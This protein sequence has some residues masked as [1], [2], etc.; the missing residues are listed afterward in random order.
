MNDRD[1]KRSSASV[2]ATSGDDTNSEA[3]SVLNSDSMVFDPGEERPRKHG[4][5]H[6]EKVIGPMVSLIFH[7]MFLLIAAILVIRPPMRAGDVGEG[8]VADLAGLSAEVVSDLPEMGFEASDPMIESSM[9]MKELSTDMLDSDLQSS[10]ISLSDASPVESLGGA[11]EDVDATGGELGG[12]GGGGTSFFGVSSRG[13]RFMYIVDVSGSMG[14]QNRL[15]I[16]KDNLQSSV[17]ALPEYTSYFIFAY[18]DQ[19]DPVDNALRW[20]VA[21]KENRLRADR[22]IKRL[23]SGGGTDPTSAFEKAF[24]FQPLP[25]VIYFM[26]DAEDLQGMPE[27]VARLNHRARRVKIHCIAFGDSGSEDAMR[28]IAKQSGGKYRFVPIGGG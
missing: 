20:R 26:T 21:S 11:G 13:R 22:W 23:S 15:S 4:R 19:A 1:A 27:F 5:F 2:S 6:S 18:N 28:R 7:G 3:G 25:D 14:A 10:E 12:G 24:R 17:D 16:L 9:D 8:E